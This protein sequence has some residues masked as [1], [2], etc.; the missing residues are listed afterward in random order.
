MQINN[1]IVNATDIF[2][3]TSALIF[4]RDTVLRWCKKFVMILVAQSDIHEYS[5]MAMNSGNTN[6]VPSDCEVIAHI[7]AA[8][9]PMH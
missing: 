1:H 7:K 4:Q 3:Q 2:I 8:G 9:L 5:L 6:I